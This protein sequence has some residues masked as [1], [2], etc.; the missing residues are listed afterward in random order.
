MRIS[1]ALGVGAFVLF[2]KIVSKKRSKDEVK[3]VIYQFAIK[4]TSIAVE[5][6]VQTSPPK[7]IWV[8]PQFEHSACRYFRWN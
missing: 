4:A 3:N 8:A 6:I 5:L 2:I 1:H 7:W